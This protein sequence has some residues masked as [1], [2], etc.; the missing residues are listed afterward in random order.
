[1]ASISRTVSSLGG[2]RISSSVI[3]AARTCMP[4]AAVAFYLWIASWNLRQW[5]QI[6]HRWPVV[7]ADGKKKKER[8]KDDGHL[9]P[10]EN[11]SGDCGGA[12]HAALPRQQ[13]MMVAFSFVMLE[14]LA[15]V[16]W[17]LPRARCLSTIA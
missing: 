8:K 17:L 12:E 10:A 9:L 6:Y 3:A 4:S 15:V 14:N 2:L 13:A 7:V 1:M 11:G 16:L 5:D